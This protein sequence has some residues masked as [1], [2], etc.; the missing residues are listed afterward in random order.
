MSLCYCEL[1]RLHITPNSRS[2][3]KN[4]LMTAANNLKFPRN[5]LTA[6]GSGES[7]YTGLLFFLIRYT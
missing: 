5:R 1:F 3:T 4:T 7:F 2:S 6:D